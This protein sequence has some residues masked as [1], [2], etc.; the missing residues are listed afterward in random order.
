MNECKKTI[1]TNGA[2][3]TFLNEKLNQSGG[4]SSMSKPPVPIS[5][6]TFKSSLPSFA[7]ISNSVTTNIPR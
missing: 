4:I 2:T 3:I 1:E 5:T 6:S 7:Q